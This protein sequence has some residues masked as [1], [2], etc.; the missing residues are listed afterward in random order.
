MMETALHALFTND[1]K[2]AETVLLERDKV[3]DLESKVVER[4]LRERLP[5]GDLSAMRLISTS[6]LPS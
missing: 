5:A 1:Y 3:S 2:L 6:S 4:L